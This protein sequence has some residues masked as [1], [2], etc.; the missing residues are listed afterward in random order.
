MAEAP[1]SQPQPTAHAQEQR[2]E[3]GYKALTRR[4]AGTKLGAVR[5][6][7]IAKQQRAINDLIRRLEA[8]ENVDPS[9]IDR[10]L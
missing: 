3:D 5:H 4:Y 9:E 6:A 1:A 7:E 8:G 10:V 2:L